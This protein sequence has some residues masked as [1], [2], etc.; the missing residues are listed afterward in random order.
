MYWLLGGERR[1]RVSN[2][3]QAFQSICDMT[4][5][6]GGWTSIGS[7][8]TKLSARSITSMDYTRGINEVGKYKYTQSERESVH[9]VYGKALVDFQF[10]FLLPSIK[11]VFIVI[12]SYLLLF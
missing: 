7:I 10:L 2:K 9:R 3:D 8:G 6:G 1:R 4:T 5:D 12:V 11:P